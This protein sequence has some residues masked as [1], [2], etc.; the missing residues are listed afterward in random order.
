MLDKT[1][2]SFLTEREKDTKYLMKYFS[3][4]NKDKIGDI[5]GL[6]LVSVSY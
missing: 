6:G 4:N 2:Y 1:S 3:N 5:S